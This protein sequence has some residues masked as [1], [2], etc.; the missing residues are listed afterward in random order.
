MKTLV[1][2]IGNILLK[3]EGVGIH[4]MNYLRE[5]HPSLKNVCFIDGGTL[6]FT[7]AADIGDC[8]QL[9]VLDAVELNDKAGVVCCLE[10][11]D[12]DEFLGTTKRSA[13]E[14]GLLDLMDICRLTESL[15]KKRALIGIQ[16]ETFD[17]G[18]EPV[19]TVKAA[20]PE[21]ASQAYQ[22]IDKYSAST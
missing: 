19:E 20:I 7:L 6:S 3:D 1:L 8:D 15:P 11:E 12:M 9:I 5:Q 10:D 17:W 4:A 21:A 22:L 14:V 2:G 13:H 18:E 16:Y